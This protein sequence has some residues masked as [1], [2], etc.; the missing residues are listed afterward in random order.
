[1]DFPGLAD[2]LASV[3]DRIRHHQARGGWTHPV[4]IVA[5]TK[6]QGANDIRAAFRELSSFVRVRMVKET[7][8]LPR[9]FGVVFQ[10]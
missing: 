10:E 4:R 5:V 6:A 8:L 7:R 3:R 2:R 1:M 9:P